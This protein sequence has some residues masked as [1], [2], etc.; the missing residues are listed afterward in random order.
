V[1]ASSVEAAMAREIK[2]VFDGVLTA[3]QREEIEAKLEQPSCGSCGKKLTKR[4]KTTTIKIT[5]FDSRRPGQ[6]KVRDE[7]LCA[8]CSRAPDSAGYRVSTG[9]TPAQAARAIQRE[10]TKRHGRHGRT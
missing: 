8:R 10:E 7:R 5:E 6:K 1:I 4:M 9:H 3:E 2:S